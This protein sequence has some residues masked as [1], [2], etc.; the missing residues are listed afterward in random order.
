M[1]N[2]VQEGDVVTVTA[3][4]A[5]TSGGGVLVGA[6]LFGVATSDIGNGAAG[7]IAVEGVFDLV[8]TFA[9]VITIGDRLFWDNIN[10]VVNKTVIS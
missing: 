7:E 9:L 4:Y 6:N 3:P 2:F 5:V 1:K 10:K 8:K